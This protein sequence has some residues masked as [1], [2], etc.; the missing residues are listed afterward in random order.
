MKDKK[1]VNQKIVYTLFILFVYMV[2]KNIPLFQVNYGFHRNEMIDAE[3]L[4][5][6][7]IGGDIH[8]CS[9]FALGVSPYMIASIIVQILSAFRDYKTRSKISQTKTNRLTLFFMMIIAV[10]QAKM[11]VGDLQFQVE[12]TMLVLAKYI[13]TLELVTG[14]SMILW[15]CSK[16]KSYGIGGQSAL[17]FVNVIDGIRASLKGNEIGTLIVPL[18]LSLVVLVVM[19]FMENS[20]VRI[21]VQRISIHNIYEDKNYLAIKLNPIGVM[22][23]MFSAAFFMVPQILLSV[24]TWFMPQSEK[25]LWWKENMTLNHPLGIITYALILYI[26]TIGFSRIFIS[27]ADLT[28]QYLKSGDSLVGI[29]AGKETKRYLSRVITGTSILSA[30]VMSICLSI[31][32]MLQMIGAMDSS[33]ASLPSSVMILTGIWC[34]LNSE[35]EA[36]KGFDSYKTFI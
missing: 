11:R 16:N 29:H 13:A 20:E 10:L 31:P 1:I 12:G 23:A 32:L 30:F 5:M 33:L 26:L 18:L 19:I 24:L 15:M 2:G 25:L 27:P 34:N 3:A 4:L 17:I 7:T 21:G 22:P 8:Q 36:I 9:I 14:A 6:Q 35:I 28:E